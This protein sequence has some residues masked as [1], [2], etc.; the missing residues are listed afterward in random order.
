MDDFQVTI[1]GNGSA[2]PTSW[3]NPTS[4]LIQYK[5]M[6]FM[7]DCGEGTQMRMITFKQK[8]R[9]LDHI[10][11]SH[12]HGDHYYGLI[13]L[14]NSY[15]LMRREKTLHLFAPKALE[16]VLQKQLE[17][18]KTRLNYTLQFHALELYTDKPLFS[19]QDLVIECFSLQH[20]IPVW[21]FLFREKVGDR[22][23]DK[24]FIA[25]Y[26]PE[27]EEIKKIKLGGDFI[28]PKGEVLA[29]EIITLPPRPPRSYAFCSDTAYLSL[30]ADYVKGVDLLYHESTFDQSKKELADKTFH[31]TAAQA[32]MVAKEAEVKKLLIGH[33][34]ARY[35]ELQLLVNEAREVFPES[36]LS[37]EG[38]SYA[39]E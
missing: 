16:E 35:S 3:H 24:S 33:Y 15:H 13:G 27:I 25:Q 19:D 20:S 37:E 7:I 10:F 12:L 38:V 32:A 2:V 39:I 28:T 26:D 4:Q 9:N 34:S 17:V 21:G 22:R 29:H 6:Q 36:Y 1:L 5:G 18:S 30:T 11:I 31:S 14:I 23:I 8:H